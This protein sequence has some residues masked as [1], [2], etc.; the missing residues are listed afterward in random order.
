MFSSR[1]GYRKVEQSLNLLMRRNFAEDRAL[2][3]ESELDYR[4]AD[5]HMQQS[6]CLL[7]PGLFTVFT[8]NALA[9]TICISLSFII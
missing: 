2:L 4:I 5:T 8:I 7:H 9:S 1:S 6:P 3:M